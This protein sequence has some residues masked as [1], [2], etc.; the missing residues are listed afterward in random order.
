MNVSK[1]LKLA[2]DISRLKDDDRTYFHG[3]VGIRKDG[4][5]VCAQNGC[6]KQPDRKHHAEYRVLRKLGREG[7]LFVVRTTAELCWANSTPC[8]DCLKAIKSSG[9]VAVFWSTGAGKVYKGLS[10]P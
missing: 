5:I 9:T 1:Y 2:A 6:P 10:F 3:A 8:N 4:V 7:V